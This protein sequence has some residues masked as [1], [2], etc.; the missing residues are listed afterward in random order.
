MDIGERDLAELGAKGF[1]RAGF[2]RV[3]A[4]FEAGRW[5]RELVVDASRIAAPAVDAL[6]GVPAAGDA[7]HARLES[8][9]RSH[10]EA[11]RVGVLILNGG[12]A[13]RFG[14]VVKGAVDVVDGRSFL[15]LKIAQVRKVAPRSPIFLMNSPA[16]H[17]RTL[18]HLAERGIED[19]RL[20]HFV[21]PVAPRIS[22]DG[23]IVRE[24]DGSISVN[25]MG[26]GDTLTAFRKGGLDRLLELGGRTVMVSNV[27]NL[28]AT[29]DPV[30]VGLHL[31]GGQPASVE[32]ARRKPTDKGGMPV[33][34]DG[35]LVLLEGM[36][37]P[38]GL[39]D[40]SYRA[41]NTN[42][43]YIETGVFSD[44]PV[45]DAYPV[46]KEVRGQ[47]VVQFERILGELTHHVP[48]TYILVEQQGALSRFIPVK[49]REDL[50]GL[51][52]DIVACLRPWGVL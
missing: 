39:D 43:F 23:R 22:L 1:D 41:F 33:L 50:E 32:V 34:L 4:D 5:D 24:Q 44:P 45:L 10:I 37:W 42:T 36:R 29:L 6:V 46:H 12:M 15:E 21:Q 14:G 51:R 48:T 2:D 26:H 16:T 9:G 38:Q 7:D 49:K 52:E 25:G 3:W 18:E 40:P 11:G 28:G 13:T 17:E 19:D 8:A 31:E 27:D 20:F 35:K 47:T 30:L